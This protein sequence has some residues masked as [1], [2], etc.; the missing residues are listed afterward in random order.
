MPLLLAVPSDIWRTRIVVFLCA[1][2]LLQADQAVV[3]CTDRTHFHANIRGATMVETLTIGSRQVQ[4]MSWFYQRGIIFD[5][6]VARGGFQRECYAILTKFLSTASVLHFLESRFFPDELLSTI[7]LACS[8]TLQSLTLTDCTMSNLSTLSCC[9][10]AVAL[11]VENCHF[12]VDS[13]LLQTVLSCKLLRRLTII[14]CKDISEATV[15][16]VLMKCSNLV[17]L[18]LKGCIERPMRLKTLSKMLLVPSNLRQFQ[19]GTCHVS[20]SALVELSQNLPH[21]ELLKLNTPND[22]VS[23]VDIAA[24]V[25][26]CTRLASLTLHRFERLSGD[27]LCSMAVHLL[28]LTDLRLESLQGAP[29]NITDNGVVALAKGCP[30]LQNLVLA[31]C[32]QLT[33]TAVQGL[34]THAKELCQ[35]HGPHGSSV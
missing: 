17:S 3:N 8:K 11:R 32:T 1:T 7:L 6:I 25:R 26:H 4:F 29:S 28:A 21:L 16:A 22:V 13:L 33:D 19:L 35:L 23:D 20:S 15:A 10:A 24:L 9:S 2:D 12:L 31:C 18:I 5:G 34:C 27:A 30:H 14:N